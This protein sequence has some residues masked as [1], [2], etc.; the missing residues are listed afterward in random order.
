MIRQQVLAAMQRYASLHVNARR[1]IGPDFVI[2]DHQ[3]DRWY[4]IPRNKI[5]NVYLHRF[6]KS[7]ED[8]ALHD[9][10]WI[11]LGWILGPD[12]GYDE[13]LKSGTRYRH[14]GSVTWRLPTTAH[15]VVLVSDVPVWTLFITGPVVRQWGFHCPQGWRHWKVFI[16]EVPGR[17][18]IGRGCE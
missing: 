8:R 17:N 14:A 6:N 10:P 9:H 18:R 7:D 15:R 3:L 11:S 16:T 2:G 1:E 13:V 5:F 4:L 12:N